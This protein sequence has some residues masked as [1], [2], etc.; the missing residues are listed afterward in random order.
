MGIIEHDHADFIAKQAT[1]RSNQI[2]GISVPYSYETL[3]TSIRHHFI[4]NLEA[5]WHTSIH[6]RQLYD[7]MPRFSRSLSWT[8]DLPRRDVSLVAQF[9][10]GHYPTNQYL[11]RFHLI[12]NPQCTWC[13][14]PIDDKNHRLFHCPRFAFL[15]QQLTSEI[16]YLTHEHGD[17]N[18][19]Y[20]SGLGRHFLARFLKAVRR[21]C[22]HH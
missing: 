18:W 4:S 11:H 13:H 16:R 20:L 22:T 8:K 15:R 9:L 10:T 1:N 17:W 3:K 14:S 21:I 12:D 5:S 6:G 7:V 2:E 19:A